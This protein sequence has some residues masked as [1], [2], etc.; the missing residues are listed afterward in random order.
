MLAYVHI[1]LNIYIYICYIRIPDTYT[2]NVVPIAVYCDVYRYKQRC[3]LV[4]KC[5]NPV[6]LFIDC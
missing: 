2:Y 1:Y 3:V 6:F 4:K 5:F